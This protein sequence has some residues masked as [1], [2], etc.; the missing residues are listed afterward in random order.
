MRGNI[1]IE[2]QTGCVQ[3]CEMATVMETVVV[4]GGLDVNKHVGFP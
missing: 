2:M 1:P 4:G 3:M